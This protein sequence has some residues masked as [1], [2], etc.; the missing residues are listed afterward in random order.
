[1]RP[2]VLTIDDSKAVR[3]I[4]EKALAPFACDV[5]ESTNGFNGLFA[6]EKELPD[7]LLLD[8]SMPVMDGVEMLTLLK[9]HAV[10]KKIPVIMMT[11]PSDH[12]VIPQ[13]TALGVA[14]RIMKPFTPEVLVA[15]VGRIL[16]LTPQ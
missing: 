2:K 5:N 10:L 9:S 15:A 3:I 12:R 11:S 8:V 4:V 16:A 13:I 6:M 1:M 7:L 14:D